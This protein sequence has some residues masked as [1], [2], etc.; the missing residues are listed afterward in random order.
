[1]SVSTIQEEKATRII[2]YEY[3]FQEKSR[4]SW[5][6]VNRINDKS[7]HSTPSYKDV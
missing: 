3:R 1:M 4:D 6:L 7:E 2:V 5:H